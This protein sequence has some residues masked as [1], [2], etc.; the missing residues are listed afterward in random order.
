MK[1]V[2]CLFMVGAFALLGCAGG[3]AADD[4]DIVVPPDAATRDAAAPDA[5]APDAAA[6]DAATPDAATPD[7]STD[8]PDAG[9]G[10]AVACNPVAQTGCAV[11]EKCAVILDDVDSGASHIGCI[12]DGTEAI[13]AACTE[14]A[15]V[16]ESDNCAAGGQCYNGL[17]H[18]ICSTALANCTGTGVCVQFVDGMGDDLPTQICLFGCDPLVQDCVADSEACYLVGDGGVCVV[19]AGG[20]GLPIGSACIYANSCVEGGICIGPAGAGVC[21]L[22]C[23]NVVDMW[24][25]VDGTLTTPSCC[26]SNCSGPT[27]LI[28]CTFSNELC[29]LI[30]DGAGGL[31]S[32]TVGFCSTD[33]DYSAD[34][35]TYT[36]NCSGDPICVSSTSGIAPTSSEPSVPVWRVR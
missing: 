5:A 30:G 11:G 18:E 28:A 32:E 9:C 14:A 3:S 34:D 31:A 36:C 20:T 25:E 23:G 35:G 29:G 19:P 16:C 27:I 6:P 33:E 1:K 26:G 7:A 10:A 2:V 4:D 15:T 17:C 24:T 22:M 21:R 13:G 12:A 8:V